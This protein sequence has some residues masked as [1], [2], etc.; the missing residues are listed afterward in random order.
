MTSSS[1][2]SVTDDSS[3]DGNTAGYGEST[4]CV[5][6]TPTSKPTAAPPTPTLD[7]VSKPTS[8]PT[9]APTSL[10]TA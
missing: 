1:T 10:T 5:L 7:P 2:L 8:E 6:L 4:E 9:V 3:I